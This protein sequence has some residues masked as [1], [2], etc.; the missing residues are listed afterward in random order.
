MLL[1]STSS[2]SSTNT[3]K[4][5]AFLRSQLKL[6]VWPVYGGVIAQVLDWMGLY[7]AS[8]RVLSFIGGRV[9]PIP[10]SDEELSPFLLLVHHT[11]SFMPFD[12]IR[13]ITKLIIPEGFPAHPHSGFGTLTFALRSARTPPLLSFI[14]LSHFLAFSGA[15]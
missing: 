14:V 10:L 2:T 15:V 8:D 9:V 7:A 4:A 1:T 3:I 12:P 5:K 13:P 11:H 6:P